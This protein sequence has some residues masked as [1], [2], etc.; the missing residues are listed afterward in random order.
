MNRSHIYEETRTLTLGELCEA[1][2]EGNIKAQVQD[3]TYRVS[4]RELMRFVQSPAPKRESLVLRRIL[5][6][7]SVAN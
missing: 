5:E 3:G 1:L 2:M 6:P 7:V 4:R